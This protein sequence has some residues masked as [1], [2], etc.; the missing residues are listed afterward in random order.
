L[1]KKKKKKKEKRKRSR[2]KRKDKGVEVCLFV[3][4]FLFFFS[5]LKYL[6]KNYKRKPKLSFRLKE[7]KLQQTKAGLSNPTINT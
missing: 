7:M 3:F 6:K 1:K 5:F 2:Q 4:S